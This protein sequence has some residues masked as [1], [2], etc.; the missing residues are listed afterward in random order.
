MKKILTAISILLGLGIANAQQVA[1]ATQ[2]SQHVSSKML[3][4]TPPQKIKTSPT[5][6]KNAKPITSTSNKAVKLKKDGTPDKRYKES[7]TLKKDGTPDKRYK[8]N[9]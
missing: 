3:K 5:V 4:K 6:S 8:A 7:Q 1:P 2:K 9:K